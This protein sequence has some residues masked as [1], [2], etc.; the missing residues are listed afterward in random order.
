MPFCSQCGNP[1]GDQDVFCARCGARQPVTPPPPP[2]P[3]WL[4]GMSPRTAA[5]LCY[6]PVVGWIAA[7]VVLAMDQFR[8][9]RTLRFH[10]FQGL[11]LFVAWLIVSEVLSPVLHPFGHIFGLG[12]LL[13]ALILFL[14]IFMI[15]KASHDEVYSLPVI[16]ELAERSVAER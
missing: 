9:N 16:G 1:A 7:V 13:H 4:S 3:D 10:A 8:N 12:K 14:W 2:S 6:I 5:V 15:I 11:Y